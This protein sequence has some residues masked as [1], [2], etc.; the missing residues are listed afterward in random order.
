M[1]EP[2]RVLRPVLDTAP[3]TAHDDSARGA[4]D[5]SATIIAFGLVAIVSMLFGFVIGLFF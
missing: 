2:K 3:D 4:P 1:S 5:R